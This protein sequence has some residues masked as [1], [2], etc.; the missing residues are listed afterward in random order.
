[1]CPALLLCRSKLA[2]ACVESTTCWALA[3]CAHLTGLSQLRFCS[4]RRA[5]SALALCTTSGNARNLRSTTQQ[6]RRCWTQLQLFVFVSMC[7]VESRA[8]LT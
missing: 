6:T 2:S 8:W 7:C 5:G 4:S 3:A 1:M